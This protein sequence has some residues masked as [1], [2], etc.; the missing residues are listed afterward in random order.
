MDKMYIPY[1]LSSKVIDWKPKW[2]Y[3]ENHGNTLLV[4]DQGP[5]IIRPEWKKKPLDTSQILDLLKLIAN[6]K[7]NQIIEEAVVFDWMKRRIQPLQARETFGFEY[8]GTSDLSRYSTKQIS[9]AEALRRV[10]QLL[11]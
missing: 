5:P 2:F 7:Q 9:N 4:I 1:K 6:L 11:E 3:I 8:Q 10:Q